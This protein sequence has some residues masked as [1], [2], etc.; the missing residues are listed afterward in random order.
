MNCSARGSVFL[1]YSCYKSSELVAIP[2]CVS[3]WLSLPTVS[4]F[5]KIQTHTRTRFSCLHPAPIFC[6]HF[7]QIHKT[8]GIFYC[9]GEVN[10]FIFCV[11]KLRPWERKQSSGSKSSEMLFIL[12]KFVA[13]STKQFVLCDS[14]ITNRKIKCKYFT[15]NNDK[16]PTKKR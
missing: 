15:C 10:R 2:P 11:I 4:Q 7:R 3:R 1:S 9:S 16:C 14:W 13:N 12:A 8:Y 6:I 5:I